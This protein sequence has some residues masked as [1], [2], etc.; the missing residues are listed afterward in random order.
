MK[1][2]IVAVGLAFSLTACLPQAREGDRCNNPGENRV[3]GQDVF[4]CVIVPGETQKNLF[5]QEFQ[6][7]RW[8]K[9]EAK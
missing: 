9:L 6:V 2:G 5:G 3:E 8:K 4:K 1:R 7:Y